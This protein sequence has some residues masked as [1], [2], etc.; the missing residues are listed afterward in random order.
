MTGGLLSAQM[1]SSLIGFILAMIGNCQSNLRVTW[2]SIGYYRLRIDRLTG[3]STTQLK[4]TVVDSIVWGCFN[5]TRSEIFCVHL[6]CPLSSSR[7]LYRT[8]NMKILFGLAFLLCFSVSKL[9]YSYSICFFFF[10]LGYK[11][12]G[13]LLCC[14]SPVPLLASFIF[15]LGVM[16]CGSPFCS[17][18]IRTIRTNINDFH[19][20]FITSLGT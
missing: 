7:E 13:T 6:K 5:K 20:C 9:F 3:A 10:R 17:L 1:R 2:V 16:G 14:S 12:K 19:S 4:S 18:S 8:C 15:F 11:R